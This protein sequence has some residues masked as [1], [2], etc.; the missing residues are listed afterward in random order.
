MNDVAIAAGASRRGGLQVALVGLGFSVVAARHRG[1]HR[2]SGHHRQLRSADR[3]DPM[4]GD[5][6]RAG[7]MPG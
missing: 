4:G 3:D 1:Q 2:L 6:L 7:R 5:L